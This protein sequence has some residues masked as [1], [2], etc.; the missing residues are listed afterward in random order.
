MSYQAEITFESGTKLLSEIAQV[1]V[2]ET[3][4]AI[5]YP[6][7]VSSNQDLTFLTEGGGI[8]LR[9]VDLLGKVIFEK[10]LQ[11]VNESIDVVNLT[12]GLYLYQLFSS[13]RAFTGGG[14]FIKQ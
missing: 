11:N 2:E 13:T 12:N 10:V 7:P 5:L 3:G 6:N 14:K 9:I 8:K 1:I 4:N